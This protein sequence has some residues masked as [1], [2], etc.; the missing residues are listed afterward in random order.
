MAGGIIMLVVTG[1]VIGAVC[2]YWLYKAAERDHRSPMVWGVFG[3]HKRL[4]ANVV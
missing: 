3:F 4:I 1:L 2:G